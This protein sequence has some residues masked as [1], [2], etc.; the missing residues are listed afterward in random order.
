MTEFGLLTAD[1]MPSVGDP[2]SLPL[3]FWVRS[4]LLQ[5]IRDVSIRHLASPDG[6]LATILVNV[7]GSTPQGWGIN[8]GIGDRAST[9]LYAVI[10]GSPGLGKNLSMDVA[11]SLLPIT[12]PGVNGPL[13]AGT[14]EGFIEAFYQDVLVEDPDKPNKLVYEHKQV[15]H[16]AVWHVGEGEKLG[17]L[18]KRPGATIFQTMRSM[19]VGSESVGNTNAS[20]ET[21]RSLAKGSFVLGIVAGFQPATAGVLLGDEGAGLPQRFI[22]LSAAVPLGDADIVRAEDV[23]DRIE[24]LDWVMPC[25]PLLTDPA[26]K[27]LARD[28][29]VATVLAAP[30]DRKVGHSDLVQLKVAACLAILH[31]EVVL[32]LEWFEVAGIIM[33]TSAEVLAYTKRVSE[34]ADRGEAAKIAQSRTSAAVH[35]QRATVESLRADTEARVRTNI[36]RLL[37]ARGPMMWSDLTRRISAADRRLVPVQP[38]IDD[39]VAGGAVCLADAPDGSRG[40]WYGL[41][42]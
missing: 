13:N 39:L 12:M 32:S 4:P 22:W 42:R 27:Q 19:F 26:I 16:G 36:V 20:K 30:E 24:P 15:F 28:R 33:E 18:A 25:G 35:T 40:V 29:R 5:K 37:S 8:T 11:K 7:A 41:D 1:G 31:G 23:P 10:M 38:V 34:D 9:S 6:V 3:E 14:G 17:Q 2:P 21:S